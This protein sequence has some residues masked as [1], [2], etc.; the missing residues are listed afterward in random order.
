[1]L[2]LSLPLRNNL[3]RPCTHPNNFAPGKYPNIQN[4]DIDGRVLGELLLRFDSL[5]GLVQPLEPI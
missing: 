1:M 2:Y 4:E 5:S 3:G